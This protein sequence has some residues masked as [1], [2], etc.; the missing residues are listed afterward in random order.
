[1]AW[2]FA[3]PPYKIVSNSSLA[4]C[5]IVNS[6]HAH[7]LATE[8][9]G[10]RFNRFVRISSLEPPLA[11]TRKTQRNTN[12]SVFAAKAEAASSK[13]SSAAST[14]M[15]RD[16]V[17]AGDPDDIAAVVEDV[18]EETKRIAEQIEALRLENAKLQE[19]MMMT[20]KAQIVPPNVIPPPGDGQKI[21]EQDPHLLSY[22]DH[23]EYR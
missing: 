10:A 11:K 22:K 18:E 16:T 1:M 17:A 4:S 12:L 15:V 13:D 2:S 20:T 21:Y 9:I 19:R 7:F 14:A 5:P 8:K 6:G 23:L 3:A